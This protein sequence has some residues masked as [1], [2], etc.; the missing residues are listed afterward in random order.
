MFFKKKGMAPEEKGMA[1]RHAKT[2]WGKHYYN[3]HL[4]IIL[5]REG[6]TVWIERKKIFFPGFRLFYS[7]NS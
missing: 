6:V 4:L 2:D 5:K 3:V 1:R 7:F